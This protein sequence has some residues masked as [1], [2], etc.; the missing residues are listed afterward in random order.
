MND[1]LK[2]YIL[3]ARLDWY[4]HVCKVYGKLIKLCEKHDGMR[5]KEWC[6]TQFENGWKKL[7]V[8]AAEIKQREGAQ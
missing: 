4:W 5:M 8:I 2:N 1:I 6:T 7:E 3:C